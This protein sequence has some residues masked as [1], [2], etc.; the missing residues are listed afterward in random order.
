MFDCLFETIQ[1]ALC[2]I[3]GIITSQTKQ[4]NALSIDSLLQI[5]SINTLNTATH[6]L[7]IF[8][9]LNIYSKIVI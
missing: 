2:C 4:Q 9:T 5:G 7:Y 6:A 3:G 8:K 1:L